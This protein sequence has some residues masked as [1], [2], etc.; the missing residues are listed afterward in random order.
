MGTGGPLL[1]RRLSRDLRRP[2][3]LHLNPALLRS[4][5]GQ[6]SQWVEWSREWGSKNQ[7]QKRERSGSRVGGRWNG[8]ESVSESPVNGGET[9]A[10]NFAAPF[11]SRALGYIYE[12]LIGSVQ[13]WSQQNKWEIRLKLHC[14]S[15]LD[16]QRLTT[17]WLN[18]PNKCF[19]A[20]PGR[21][22]PKASDI[23]KIL[24]LR[25]QHRFKRIISDKFASNV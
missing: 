16:I 7:V 17:D 10:G 11:R 25:T 15:S 9:W 8:N 12:Y 14:V 23:S 2:L 6:K 13:I 4:G 24:R 1:A 22:S 20:S 5:A 18:R 21:E 3:P 19:I